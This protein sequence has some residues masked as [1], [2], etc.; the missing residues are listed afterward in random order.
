MHEHGHYLVFWYRAQKLRTHADHDPGGIP[1]HCIVISEG[2]SFMALANIVHVYPLQVD[3][4]L[5]IAVEYGRVDII[6]H[7]DQKVPIFP[8]YSPAVYIEDT[9]PR[10]SILSCPFDRMPGA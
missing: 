10:I 3:P 1:A 2:G 9:I 7:F 6:E 4:G 5:E 8:R